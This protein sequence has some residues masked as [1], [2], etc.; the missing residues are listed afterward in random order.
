[1]LPPIKGAVVV[2]CVLA[3]DSEE[4]HATHFF[5]RDFASDGLRPVE[6][7]LEALPDIRVIQDAVVERARRASVPVVE[8]TELTRTIAAVMELVLASTE[9]LEV[10]AHGGRGG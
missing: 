10:M 6:R 9:R 3:I 2:H 4:E 8:N 1:L 5:V 7:Y